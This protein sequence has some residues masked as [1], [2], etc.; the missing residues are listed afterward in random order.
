MFLFCSILFPLPL[1][2]VL[3]VGVVELVWKWFTATLCMVAVLQLAH[4]G[5]RFC[6]LESM[7]Y[8]TD[9]R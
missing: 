8:L 4:T 2:G 3:T 7:L 1:L 9:L 5:I 6:F